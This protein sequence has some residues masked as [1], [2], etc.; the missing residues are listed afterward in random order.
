MKRGF[1]TK[2]S[3]VELVLSEGCVEDVFGFSLLSRANV[4]PSTTKS[5][6]AIMGRTWG[7]DC[8]RQHFQ[9][10]FIQLILGIDTALCQDPSDDHLMFL[11]VAYFKMCRNVWLDTSHKTHIDATVHYREAR[12]FARWSAKDRES[13]RAELP[14]L[15]KEQEQQMRAYLRMMQEHHGLNPDSDIPRTR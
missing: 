7:S 13:R 1:A 3:V 2:T 11:Q 8:G 14:P 6:P 12:E 9:S 5:Q 15:T 4:V 10:E